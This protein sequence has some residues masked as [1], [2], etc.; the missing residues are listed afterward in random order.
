[1]I[2]EGEVFCYQCEARFH[3]VLNLT[4]SQVDTYPDPKYIQRLGSQP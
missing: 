1:L 4:Q 2:S 3:R